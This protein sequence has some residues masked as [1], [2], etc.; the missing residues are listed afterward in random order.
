MIELLLKLLDKL[1]QLQELRIARKR[2]AFKEL[3]EPLFNELQGVHRDYLMNFSEA[4][5][6]VESSPDDLRSCIM[7]LKKRSAEFDPVRD[8]LVAFSKTIQTQHDAIEMDGFL[9]AIAR[10]FPTGNIEGLEDTIFH[11]GSTAYTNLISELER[12]QNVSRLSVSRWDRRPMSP[13]TTIAAFMDHLQEK[14]EYVCEAF[15]KL[16]HTDVS[17]G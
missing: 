17:N 1:G 8:K 6:L 3:A 5:A 14:W 9:S 15:A 12:M 16:K 2:K 13:E 10:Y 7:Y 11:N 4:R